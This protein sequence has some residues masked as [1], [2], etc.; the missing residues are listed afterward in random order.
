M[1]A[2]CHPANWTSTALG[3]PTGCVEIKLVDCPSLSYLSSHTPNPQGE[4][5]IRG[6]AV[7]SGYLSLPDENAAAFTPDGWFKTGDIGEFA[8]A[9]MHGA[10][11]GLLRVI[12]RKKNMVKTL[13]GEYIALEKLESIYRSCA[14]VANICVVAAEDR[15]RPIAIVVPAEAALK[16]LAEQNGVEG[17][18]VQDLAASEKLREMALRAIQEAGRRGGLNGIEIV[19]NIVV[20]REEWTPQNVSFSSFFLISS[21]GFHFRVRVGREG[22]GRRGFGLTEVCVLLGFRHQRAKG[23]SESYPEGIP[24][25]CRQGVRSKRV[26][27]CGAMERMFPNTLCLR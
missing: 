15:S 1:G 8:D 25:G 14:L 26:G 9:D 10:G 2:I 21:L 18:T 27:G 4:I 23:Q 24:D 16:S 11:G 22:K 12:D 19:E 17:E 13:N 20:A 5:W 7:T 6:P 3:Q